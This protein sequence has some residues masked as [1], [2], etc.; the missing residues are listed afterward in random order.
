[1][2]KPKA[3]PTARAIG[4]VSQGLMPRARLSPP[5]ATRIPVIMAVK[6][7]TDS[8]E[9]SIWPPI[10]T[11]HRPTDR[12][13]TKVAWRRILMK[14]PIWKNWSMAREKLIRTTTRMNQTR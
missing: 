14:I 4:R 9:R 5:L 11:R 10:K 7:M 8:M 3:A 12:M 1:M 2:P 13:P 6:A